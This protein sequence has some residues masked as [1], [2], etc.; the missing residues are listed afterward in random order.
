M[1]C[2]GC[3]KE[4]SEHQTD[5]GFQ[6][7]DI[8]WQLSE[9]EKKKRAKFDSDLCRLDMERYF[10]RG[11][12][13]IPFQSRSDA[14]AW[15]FWA[16]VTK[17]DFFHYVDIYDKDGSNEPTIRGRLA[18]TPEG[19]ENLEGYPVIVKFGLPSKRPIFELL[20]S[21]HKLYQEQVEGITDQRLHE[22]LK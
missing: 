3:G 9:D 5:M 13:L 6:L 8:V 11:V 18:N 1:K 22:I 12:T 15:G 20:P 10:V 19:Y 14:F 16:E 17:D 4:I 21:D 7:P 2:A